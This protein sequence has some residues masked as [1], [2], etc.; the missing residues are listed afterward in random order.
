MMLRGLPSR[1][2]HE[3][4]AGSTR[5]EYPENIK[6]T[7]SCRVHAEI[8]IPIEVVDDK[9]FILVIVVRG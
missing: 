1:Q 3:A 6:R 8:H 4:M 7:L 2:K 9:I 5:G